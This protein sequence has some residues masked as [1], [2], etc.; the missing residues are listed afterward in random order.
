[1]SQEK[2]RRNNRTN[3]RFLAWRAGLRALS[4]VAPPLAERLATDLFFRPQRR[5]EAPR[6]LEA[7]GKAWRVRTRAGWLT[8]WDYG[9]GPTV[10]LLHGWSGAAAQWSRFI[11][12]LVRAGFNAVALDLPAHG[13]SDGTRTDLQEW[14]HAILDTAKRVQPIH[15][16]VAHSFGATAGILALGQGLRAER[17]VLIAPA[18]RDV[19]GYVHAFAQK[20]GL[21][22]A[23]E[24]GVV[25]RIERKL[26]DLDRFDARQVVPTLNAPALV[27]HD[28]DDTEVPFLEGA[29]LA[30]AWPGAR[31]QSLHGLGHYR[32]LAD[33]EVVRKAVAFI[34]TSEASVERGALSV[35]EGGQLESDAQL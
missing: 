29:S 16:V 6:V 14:V 34:A 30:R 3:G 26:G 24:R 1:M 7:E 25:A 2:S 15:A 4:V 18:A 22:R 11:D 20:I 23:R 35:V 10:L 13:F 31:I 28:V 9:V 21:P 17:A 19:A 8:A 33:P 27:L 5:G 32:P 12:P